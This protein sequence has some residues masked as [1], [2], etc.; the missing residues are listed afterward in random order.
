[1]LLRYGF[2]GLLVAGALPALSFAP[3]QQQIAGIY[4]D[5]SYN[6][7]SG[8]LNGTEIF[9]VP[10]AGGTAWAA[11]VQEAEGGPENPVVVPVVRKGDVVSIRAHMENYTVQFDGRIGAKGFD[12]KLTTEANGK[13]TTEPF[14]LRRKKSYWEGP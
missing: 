1:M 10:S 6:R 11:F 8:D 9:I 14:H 5:L 12:G 7:E 4:S 2:M 3:S 13:K